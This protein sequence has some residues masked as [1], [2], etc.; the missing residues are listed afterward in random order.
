MYRT[1]VLADM[2]RWIEGREIR[3]FCEPLLLYGIKDLYSACPNTRSVA[4]TAR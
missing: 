1:A 2:R 4:V 3:K